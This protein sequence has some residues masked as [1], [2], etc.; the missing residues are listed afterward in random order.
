M[1]GGLMQLVNYGA[2]DVFLMGNPQDIFN[3]YDYN[4]VF[5]KI[6]GKNNIYEKI[7]TLNSEFN[8]LAIIDAFI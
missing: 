1:G 2:Q 5:K 4:Y 8:Y 7:I 6:N 3:D